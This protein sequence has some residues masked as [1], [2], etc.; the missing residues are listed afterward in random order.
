MFCP[1]NRIED[2]RRGLSSSRCIG[3]TE[4]KAAAVLG[5]H[6]SV[7]RVVVEEVARLVIGCAVSSSAGKEEL[8]G[9]TY[10]G[11]RISK[12]WPRICSRLN[13]WWAGVMRVRMRRHWRRASETLGRL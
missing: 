9:R 5:D 8:T 12:G 13:G 11:A 6:N 3:S 1:R 7:A 10:G 2:V 4:K